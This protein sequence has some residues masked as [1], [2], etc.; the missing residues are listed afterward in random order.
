MAGLPIIAN[1]HSP[2]AKAEFAAAMAIRNPGHGLNH[3]SPLHT[4]LATLIREN[5]DAHYMQFPGKHTQVC[6]TAM[7]SGYHITVT[8]PDQSPQ[9]YEGPMQDVIAAINK[10]YFEKDEARRIN[11]AAEK[12]NFRKLQEAVNAER[13]GPQG[14]GIIIARR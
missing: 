12:E 8:M 2:Q 10:A 13:Q 1:P 3:R 9:S 5:I 6:I 7:T 14:S 4:Y 11:L